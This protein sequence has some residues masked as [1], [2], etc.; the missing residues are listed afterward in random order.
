MCQVLIVDDD[1]EVRELLR[2]ALEEEGHQ[3]S[4][5]AGGERAI[6]MLRDSQSRL[7]VI[8]DYLMPGVNGEAVL[9]A[10]AQDAYLAPRHAYIVMSAGRHLPSD[11]D[12]AFS[13]LW[14]RA[15]SKP[16]DLNEVSALIQ[17]AS[18]Y[19]EAQP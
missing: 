4:E 2:L 12:E 11:Q 19:L 6:G 8:L 15:L 18:Q 1:T 13:H 9:R 5:A 7:V 3:V 10:M 16:F 14:L 17:Q